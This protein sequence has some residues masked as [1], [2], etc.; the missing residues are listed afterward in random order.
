M[1]KT[2][3]IVFA[4]FLGT[5]LCEAQVPYRET[6]PDV[7]YSVAG[8]KK[9]SRLSDDDALFTILAFEDEDALGN[10]LPIWYTDEAIKPYFQNYNPDYG[11]TLFVVSRMKNKK[12]IERKL[13]VTSYP[14]YILVGPDRRILTRSDRAEDIIRYVTTNL[15]AY[16]ETDWAA[17]LLKAKDLFD[18]GQ[19]FAARR[20]VSDCLRHVRWDENFPPEAHKTIPRIVITMK[21]D[22]MYMDFVGDIKHKYNLGLLSEEDVAPFQSEFSRIHLSSDK[23]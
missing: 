15:S 23:R 20:I 19:V 7:R 17:Y 12:A 1:R 3:P 14:E 22:D 2:L 8:E 9:P 5:T 18:A 10:T 6:V 16:A 4:L 21:D 13:G 11:R